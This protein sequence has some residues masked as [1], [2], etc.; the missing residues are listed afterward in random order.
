[1]RKIYLILYLL[2]YSFSLFAQQDTTR[3]A[4]PFS[5]AVLPI[6]YSTP[7]TSW[8][9]GIGAVASARLG[10]DTSTYESQATV[11][12]AYTLEDQFLTY[13]SWRIFTNENKHVLA[14]ELGWYRYVYYYYG[15]GNQV[16][17]EEER[18]VYE[19]TYPRLRLDYLH[20]LI[21][22]WY[23][24]LRYWMDDFQDLRPDPS[25]QLVQGVL[26]VTGGVISGLGPL[27]TYD[28]R[29]SQLYP[30]KGS[31]LAASWQFYTDFLGSDYT[32]DRW[33]L[34]ARRVYG[35]GKSRTLV[36]QFYAEG[37]RGDVPFYALPQLGG[38]RL[39]RGL[40][41]GKYRDNQVYAGQVD[42][43]QKVWER[44]GY[45]LFTGVGTV[46][47]SLGDM[48]DSV[49]KLTYGLGFRYQLSKTSLLN[50]RLDLAHS[51]G[52]DFRFYLTF[53]EAF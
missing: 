24:G 44:W 47:E 2:G 11:G 9:F 26:G 19:V 50:I 6:V 22:N 25:G 15:Q 33:M 5:W 27:I 10:A 28:D 45:V 31:Y 38:N 41:E 43:R 21:G 46:T 3:Q 4:K 1:M 23:G 7:E 40:F 35:L 29:D 20:K 8:A 37:S 32:Y 52:E 34:D 18:E 17:P 53:G 36:G 51:P 14:G 12:G 42:Y 16:V 39:L 49:T 30:T 48:S 13:A